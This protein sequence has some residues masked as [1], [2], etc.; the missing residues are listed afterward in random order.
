MTSIHPFKAILPVS[1]LDYI[2][3]DNLLLVQSSHYN[4]QIITK[5]GYENKI[6]YIYNMIQKNL[7]QLQQNENFYCC[8]VSNEE[9]TNQ[10]IGLIALVEVDK[11]GKTIFKHERCI[12][13]K[14]DI[15]INYFQRYKTQLTP[16]V[17][18]H[19]GNKYISN[20]LNKI[21][22]HRHPLFSINDYKYQYD[23]WKV[24]DMMLCKNLYESIDRFVVADG[25][26]RLSSIKALGAKFIMAFLTSVNDIQ[27]SN[28]YREYFDVNSVSKKALLS[29]ADTNF[30]IQKIENNDCINHL[31]ILSLIIDSNIYE[32][33]N[34]EDIVVRRTILEFLDKNINYKNDKLNFCN[35]LYISNK[36]FFMKD[37]SNLI[38]LIPAFQITSEIKNTY[39]YPP[40][41]TLLYPKLPEGLVSYQL[42]KF[43]P[44]P[45]VDDDKL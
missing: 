33:I 21:V 45:L 30:G 11:I 1:N 20:N 22:N 25:H 14:E 24:D 7:L 44:Y 18:M 27:S 43:S 42:G 37:K 12:T 2:I 40:H 38:V 16:I 31:N 13:I 39:I 34:S 10:T 41:S 35:S 15:Y 5:Q 17:L 19:E 8:R 6:I 29:F 26:H 32:I 28:I 9:F 36:N 4:N 3:E 23:I